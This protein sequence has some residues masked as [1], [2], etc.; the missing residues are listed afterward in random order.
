MIITHM[1]ND[2]L[3]L[4]VTDRCNMC[5]SFCH[6]EGA[7]GVK[8]IAIDNTNCYIFKEL[9]QTFSRVHIT[10]GEPTLYKD[11]GKLIDILSS[12]GYKISI[13]TNG[14]FDLSS[15]ADTLS[16]INSINFSLH[17]LNKDFLCNM[18]SNVGD[19]KK[20]IINNILYFL[21]KTKVSINTVATTNPYQDIDEVIDFSISNNI[22]LNILQ[23]LS[24]NI[25]STIRKN[26]VNRGFSADEKILLY[27]SSNV[28]TIFHNDSGNTIIF[29]EI[30]YF[31]PLFLCNGCNLLNRCSEGFS[32]IRL[33]DNPL[34]VRLCIDKDTITYEEF[35]KYYYRDLKLLYED[36]L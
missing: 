24:N 21:S 5:C 28:R 34:K 22:T 25:L 18:V 33:E 11:L 32:F 30:E 2:K 27:P 19:Y 14:Y 23:E 10:G 13:T 16:N 1:L 35:V 17:S 12:Y 29:K 9:R 36:F 26:I 15:V 6:A 8:D 20:N 3:R 4:K 31:S 7:R